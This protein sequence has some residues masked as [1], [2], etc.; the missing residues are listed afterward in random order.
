MT[1]Y[2]RFNIKE[3]DNLKTLDLFH[4]N[5][6][7][8][9]ESDNKII[10]DLSSIIEIAPVKGD[11]K[12]VSMKYYSNGIKNTLIFSTDDRDS[13]LSKVITMKDRV[14]KIISDYSIETFKCYNLIKID[15]QLLTEIGQKLYENSQRKST[16]L[17]LK[18]PN[19]NEHIAFFTLYRTYS[20]INK[21]SS[22]EIKIYYIN[23]SK[24]LKMQIAPNIYGLILEDIS[25]IRIA[26]IPFNQKDFVTIKN[27][28]I[29]YA[30][31]YLNYEIKYEESNDFLKEISMDL[32]VSKSRS[33]VFKKNKNSEKNNEGIE[34]PNININNDY[35]IKNNLISELMISK[36]T[37]S[38][39]VGK[40]PEI[41]K[42]INQ[43]NYLFSYNNIRRILFNNDK[44]EIILKGYYDYL[45]LIYVNH[46]KPDIIKLIDIFII[47][48]KSEQ[49]SNFE[50]I[51]YGNPPPRFIF[52]VQNKNKILNDI[53][54]L[55]LKYYKSININENF[56][57]FS[58]KT[59]IKRY[60]SNIEDQNIRKSIE[61][62]KI[63]EIMY[64]KEDFKEII[65]EIVFN[66][67][68]LY[69]KSKKVETLLNEPITKILIQQF[70]SCYN[71]CINCDKKD[72]KANIILLNLILILFKNFGL[73]LVM[74]D[75]G[76]KICE[77]IFQK[78]TQE[79]EDKNIN[80]KYENL[81]ILNDYA[82]FYNAIHII[83]SFSLYKQIMLLKIMSFN[84]KENIL[85]SDYDSMYINFLLILFETKLT[86]MKQMPDNYVPESSYYLLLL[87][88]F[89]ILFYEPPNISRNA[90]S[91]L[92]TIIEKVNEK[93]Q[94]DI[95]E[96]LLKKTMIF[97]TL[98]IIYLDNN[99]ND[100][101]VTRNCLKIFPILLNQYYEMTIPIKNIFPPI[102]IKMLGAKKDPDKWDKSECE[103]FFIDILRDYYDEKIIWNL[104]C[105]T[106]L[107]ESLQN[108]IV[109][110]EE[111]I[112]KKLID[113]NPS[114]NETNIN[115][116]KYL[117]S[118]IFNPSTYDKLDFY[119]KKGVEYKP[120]YCI[121]YLNFKVNYKT[122]KK[123]VYILDTYINVW[124]DKMKKEKIEIN[125]NN[126]QKY[127]KKMKKEIVNFTDEKRLIII[128][129]MKLLYEKYFD[130]IGN[131]SCYNILNR[132][133]KITKSKN[134]QEQIRQLF[135]LSLS[136]KIN[137]D[138]IKENN[139]NDI[140]KE[141]INYIK[142]S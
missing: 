30:T 3:D 10:I 32:F 6:V 91:L 126:P 71:K 115:I 60:M 121:D 111:S 114:Y 89:K 96:I 81:I 76:K 28:I 102:L 7:I 100:I 131:F 130:I 51:L 20:V 82:L 112:Q 11:K 70:D 1:D 122:L 12:Q 4:N 25:K 67:Y 47:V 138:E 64:E 93:K 42:E 140:K 73:G 118:L 59:S 46:T 29:S 107:I 109:E 120:L 85:V 83:V 119:V 15:S 13:L 106:E 90:I 62:R 136:T 2:Q 55:L 37:I 54:E 127:W 110:Y 19:L 56:L 104:E 48:V 69:G 78:L 84:K 79:L 124:I 23:L 128:N 21:L 92:S 40:M 39:K 9:N 108:L 74:N 36:K 35:N 135:Y 95:K 66:F 87:T 43:D 97:Y 142:I 99:N 68:F 101:I 17:S 24:I 5:I 14:S 88:I 134:L 72:I 116:F 41:Y 50:I 49:E 123:Q 31:K 77:K 80:K 75:K 61:E 45:Q 98:I 33:S 22:K 34:Q 58:Y 16:K 65:S 18:N 27:L 129:V 139:L 63:E 137:D 52:E 53:I 94:R 117:M 113:M 86:D 103:K 133:Y 38:T 8:Q 26:I 132:I 141:D 57:L 105:K 125:I 44:S